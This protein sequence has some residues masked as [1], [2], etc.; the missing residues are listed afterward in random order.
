MSI[1]QVGQPLLQTATVSVAATVGEWLQVH[2][3]T[4][5]RVQVTCPVTW[6][7]QATVT[8]HPQPGPYPQSKHRPP[9]WAADDEEI[10]LQPKA[11]Q[12][13]QQVAATNHI[14]LD[15]IEVR[16]QS[17]VPEGKG[18]ASSTSDLVAL[19]AA[20]GQAAHAPISPPDMHAM[21]ISIE[22][23]DAIM[24]PG[25]V[26]ATLDEAQVLRTHRATPPVAFVT[27]IPS[28]SLETVH[29]PESTPQPEADRLLQAMQTALTDQHLPTMGRLATESGSLAQDRIHTP[30][31]DLVNAIGQ[32]YDGLGVIIGHSGTLSAVICDT[33][34][35]AHTSRLQELTAILA[36]ET[37]YPVATA[38]PDLAGPLTHA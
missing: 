20:I 36:A 24:Y 11:V 4:F 2:H 34:H 32:A 31:W 35:R 22:A 16:V 6:R 29:Q 15:H 30:H 26:T 28:A 3:P 8:L 1:G 19:S 7:T 23:T 5:G 14:P 27:V 21:A 18:F 13:L 25:L 12:I 17:P 38:T 37:G 33:T 10:P 9:H